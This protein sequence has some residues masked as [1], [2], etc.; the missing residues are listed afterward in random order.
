MQI[1]DI[2][3]DIDMYFQQIIELIDLMIENNN[4]S[5][6]NLITLRD[7]AQNGLDKVKMTDIL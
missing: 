4:S 3:V 1:D 2:I 5:T 7:I 6:P